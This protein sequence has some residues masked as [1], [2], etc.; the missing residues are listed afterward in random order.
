MLE[1]T[2]RRDS[3]FVRPSPLYDQMSSFQ[4]LMEIFENDQMDAARKGRFMKEFIATAQDGYTA[5]E[6][7]FV[8]SL[9]SAISLLLYSMRV[10]YR[11]FQFFIATISLV[12]I[13][14]FAFSFTYQDSMSSNTSCRTVYS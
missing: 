12:V 14:L 7:P 9:E 10:R 8:L 2:F 6:V 11:S 4:Q 13:D 1:S 3:G 5:L